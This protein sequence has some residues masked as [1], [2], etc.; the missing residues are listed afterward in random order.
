MI[1]LNQPR[2]FYHAAKCLSF[3]T[4]IRKSFITQP[5]RAFLDILGKL[6][7]EDMSP[8]G[9]GALMAKMLAQRK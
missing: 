7:L 9:I 6:A 1:N 4:A 2:P 3:K 8:K 5:A